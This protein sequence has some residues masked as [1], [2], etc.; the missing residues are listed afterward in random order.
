M[1]R[2]HPWRSRQMGKPSQ[3]MTRLAFA[4]QSPIDADL[5]ELKKKRR[6]KFKD[7][8]LPD[9]DGIGGTDDSAN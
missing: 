7:D 6:E 4:A 1:T 8:E 9:W 5:P 3:R 2:K